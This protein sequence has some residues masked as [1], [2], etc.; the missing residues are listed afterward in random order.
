MQAG[1]PREATGE[2]DAMRRI[3]VQKGQGRR[4]DPNRVLPLDPRD[5]EVLRAKQSRRPS[6]ENKS[7]R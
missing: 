1:R 6:L 5:R 4:E 3:Q 2:G 7:A